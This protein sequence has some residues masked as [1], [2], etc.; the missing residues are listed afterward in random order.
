MNHQEKP[1]LLIDNT[2]RILAYCPKNKNRRGYVL[3]TPRQFFYFIYKLKK[4]EC[5][6]SDRK[7]QPGAK[8]LRAVNT[9]KKI[10]IEDKV[11]FG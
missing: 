2:E 7:G 4:K 8:H 6:T 3:V 1:I 9:V 5:Q 10:N 11:L